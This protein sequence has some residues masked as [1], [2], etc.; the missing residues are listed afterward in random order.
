MLTLFNQLSIV[1]MSQR[2]T[3]GKSWLG[4]EHENTKS[5]I[6][7]IRVIYTPPYVIDGD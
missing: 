3:F 6:A 1:L 4:L 7:E 2:S 5:E